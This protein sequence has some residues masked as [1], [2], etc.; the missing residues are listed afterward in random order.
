MVR[1]EKKF[2][3]KSAGIQKYFEEF[4]LNFFSKM[5][6]FCAALDRKTFAQVLSSVEVR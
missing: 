6:I 3:R 4:L 5:A 2:N 1:F